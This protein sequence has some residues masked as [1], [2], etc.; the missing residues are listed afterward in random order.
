MNRIYAF[1][2]EYVTEDNELGQR[3]ARFGDEKHIW[4]KFEVPKY[5]ILFNLFV[6]RV[7]ELF[8]THQACDP[9][10]LTGNIEDEDDSNI[11]ITVW[12]WEIG[13]FANMNQS[14]LSEKDFDNIVS[15]MENWISLIEIEQNTMLENE[16]NVLSLYKYKDFKSTPTYLLQKVFSLWRLIIRRDYPPKS[17]IN[18]DITLIN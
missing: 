12:G 10:V 6:D 9:I 14:L 8:T 13:S 1:V 17:D 5:S 11:F 7:T 4:V 2:D 18:W 16:R 3:L 15:K